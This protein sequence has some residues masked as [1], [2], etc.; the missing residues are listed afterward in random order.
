M[1]I[2]DFFKKYPGKNINDYYSYLRKNA[3]SNIFENINN[4]KDNLSNINEI[5]DSKNIE[6]SNDFKVKSAKSTAIYWILGGIIFINLFFRFYTIQEINLSEGEK[7][8]EKAK[9]CLEYR[10]KNRSVF[11]SCQKEIREEAEKLDSIELNKYKTIIFNEFKD[12][13][14][15]L[16]N[17]STSG[18]DFFKFL[19]NSFILFFLLAYV[20]IIMITWIFFSKIE[21]NF[22]N[23]IMIE[24]KLDNILL[25]FKSNP[26]SYNRI[27]I[28]QSFA[29]KHNLF[30]YD[31]RYCYKSLIYGG[32]EELILRVIILSL[33]IEFAI[34]YISKFLLTI[35][36]TY[37]NLYILLDLLLQLIIPSWFVIITLIEIKSDIVD[38]L[39]NVQSDFEHYDKMIKT[40]KM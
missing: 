13:N 6:S 14:F 3:T 28:F 24:N 33:Y 4:Q 17:N 1:N 26:D 9:R 2:E 29:S 35:E 37:P 39:K 31:R 32:I 22:K 12:A 7:L 5:S 18:F 38:P 15:E 16:T 36:F 19:T 40:N 20:S 34:P 25:F 11:Q 23:F 27:E 10:T 21:S 8:A 30:S